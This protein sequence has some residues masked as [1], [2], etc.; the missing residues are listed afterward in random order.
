MPTIWKSENAVKQN[1]KM[2]NPPNVIAHLSP[3]VA[4]DQLL[5][6]VP[7]RVEAR[8]A[9]GVGQSGARR[10]GGLALLPRLLLQP[11]DVASQPGGC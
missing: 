8:G 1:G 5:R 10:P 2:V 9:V 4:A 11:G 3:A 7:R 6:L